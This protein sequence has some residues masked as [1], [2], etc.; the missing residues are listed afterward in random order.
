MTA[1]P[2]H[3]VPHLRDGFIV[4]KVGIVRSTT[5][6]ANLH[7]AHTAKVEVSLLMPASPRTRVPHLRDGFIVAKVGIVRSTTAPANLPSTETSNVEV[8][9]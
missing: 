4:A 6:P 3:R 2:Q 5:A 1:F 9:S 8:E 7:S